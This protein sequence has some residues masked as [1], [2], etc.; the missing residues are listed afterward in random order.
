VRHNHAARPSALSAKYAC[1]TR[2]EELNYASPRTHAQ[3]CTGL[4]AG[5][6][7]SLLGRSDHLTQTV[8]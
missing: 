5:R 4:L 6:P 8:I 7:T 1:R 3:A 2:V